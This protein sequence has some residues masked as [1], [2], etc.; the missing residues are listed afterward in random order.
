[1]PA[2]TESRES[3]CPRGW[4]AEAKPT[5]ARFPCW[6]H[7]SP[8][9]FRCQ[10]AGPVSCT[11][12]GGF[13]GTGTSV[14]PA[15]ATPRWLLPHRGIWTVPGWHRCGSHPRTCG[16]RILSEHQ[17]RLAASLGV[18]LHLSTSLPKK[19]DRG[20]VRTA[21]V[22]TDGLCS[23]AQNYHPYSW[24]KCGSGIRP[25]ILTSRFFL[26]VIMQQTLTCKELPGV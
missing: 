8:K 11:G 21:V 22:F 20:C 12:H 4:A 9:L 3:G 15:E 10:P 18:T 13:L 16:R 23:H 19:W 6:F 7:P 1:M 25:P 24:F 17:A 2:Q 26:T 5:H 14:T